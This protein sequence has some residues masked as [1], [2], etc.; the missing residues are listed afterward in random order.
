MMRKYVLA[1]TLAFAVT[2]AMAGNPGP[3]RFGLDKT[4]SPYEIVIDVAGSGAA[5]NKTIGYVSASGL[6][7]PKGMAPFTCAAHQ[8]LSSSNASAV[9]V[10]SQ[11][12]AADLSNGTTGSG[13]VV[14]ATGGA[15]SG[16][17]IS[18]STIT[19]GSVNNTPIGQATPAAGAFTTLSASTPIS[20]AS[21]GTGTASP[22]LVAGGGIAVAGPWPNQTI[23][24]TGT[25]GWMLITTLTAT[26]GV[27]TSLSDTTSFTSAYSEYQLEVE[28]FQGTT[29]SSYCIFQVYSSGS[30]QT[31]SYV[32]TY[33][34]N[35]SGGTPS[36]SPTA[37]MLCGNLGALTIAEP[38]GRMKIYVTDPNPA[39]G[40]GKRAFRFT[41]GMVATSAPAIVNEHGSGW[42][43]GGS[44]AI[45]GFRIYP[46]TSTAAPS[47]S[48]TF[49]RATTVKI[50]GRN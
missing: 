9:P 40:A 19:G 15:Q 11:P 37:A 36:T 35:G 8:W 20:I 38:Y 23:S 33:N 5:S 27:T 43:N 2:A 13:S 26:P 48:V 29:A 49:S 41:D 17:T 3:A 31:A 34:G 47:V 7:Y 42:W 45:T 30:Y 14:L 32:S 22:G 6:A 21:G 46:A 1:G 25:S 44:T 18:G 50:Y 39:S 10:C 12:A 16:Q 4:V 28:N 24:A